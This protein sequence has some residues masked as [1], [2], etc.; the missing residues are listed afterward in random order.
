MFIDI[1]K[2][3]KFSSSFVEIF[4]NLNVEPLP[5]VVFTPQNIEHPSGKSVYKEF[6]LS[7]NP[8]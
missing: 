7:N 1:A 6:I 5:D 4:L 2:L 3:S 8:L